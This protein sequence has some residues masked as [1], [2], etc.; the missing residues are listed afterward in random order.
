M[1]I[2]IRRS[3]IRKFPSESGNKVAVFISGRQYFYSSTKFILLLVRYIPSFYDI[4]IQRNLVYNNTVLFRSQIYFLFTIQTNMLRPVIA[5][6]E[7]E[8]CSN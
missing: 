8:T 2:W 4:Y 3:L 1:K 6:S 5:L 7:A